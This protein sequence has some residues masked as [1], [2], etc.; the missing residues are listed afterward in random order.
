MYSSIY[1]VYICIVFIIIMCN[2]KGL[3]VCMNYTVV[4]IR[5]DTCKYRYSVYFALSRWCSCL[6]QEFLVLSSK[7][8][9][10]MIIL[11]RGALSATATFYSTTC[12]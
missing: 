6:F 11:P 2:V 7:W 10:M 4:Y 3:E 12:M 9:M 1:C 8:I 5:K